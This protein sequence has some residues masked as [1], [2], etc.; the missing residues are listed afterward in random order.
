MPL[1]N[2]ISRIDSYLDH[3]AKI[4]VW[5]IST[6]L[7]IAALSLS[8]H[9]SFEVVSIEIPKHITFIILASNSVLFALLSGVQIRKIRL[10]I[11][12]HKKN[13]EELIEALSS[14]ASIFNMFCFIKYAGYLSR[15]QALILYAVHVTVLYLSAF[16]YYIEALPTYYSRHSL[17]AAFELTAGIIVI[18]ISIFAM[19]SWAMSPSNYIIRELPNSKHE[20]K[21]LVVRTL[22][23]FRKMHLIVVMA[24]SIAILLWL[25]K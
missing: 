3:I 2:P 20:G 1:L 12:L 14:H 18:L 10:C 9:T 25:I 13:K 5:T 4:S 23:D 22:K 11:H 17:S 24:T 21:N 15:L 16:S 6:S 19:H 8:S 7:T